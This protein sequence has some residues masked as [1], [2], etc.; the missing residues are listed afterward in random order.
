MIRGAR[1]SLNN[2]ST[3]RDQCYLQEFYFT[4]K[5]SMAV[6]IYN[7]SNALE[8]VTIFTINSNKMNSK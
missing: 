7:A 4:A 5:E 8:K 1:V 2:I 6:H 3:I